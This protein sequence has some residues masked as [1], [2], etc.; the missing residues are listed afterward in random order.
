M[1]LITIDALQTLLGAHG[2]LGRGTIEAQYWA[3]DAPHVTI[4][5]TNVVFPV[6]IVVPIRSGQPTRPLDIPPTGGDSCVRWEIR[7]GIGR[8]LLLIRYTTIPATGPIEFGDLTDVDPNSYQRSDTALAAWEAVLAEAV[9]AAASAEY[10]ADRAG[11]SAVAAAG[12]ASA[13]AGSVSTASGAAGAAGASATAAAGSATAAGAAHTGAEAA[14]DT[15][16]TAR[17][18]AQTAATGAA[19]SASAA[20]GSAGAA[21]ASAT[22]AAGSA[23]AAGTARTGAE[24]ARDAAL[25][26]NWDG[27][28]LATGVDLD[29]I[30]TTGRYRFGSAVASSG[31]GFPITGAGGVLE[32]L[33]WGTGAS[34]VLQRITYISGAFAAGGTWTRRWNG[35]WGAWAWTPKLTVDSPADQPG[36]TLSVIEGASGVSRQLG[37]V[38]TVLG[39]VDLNLVT[40]VGSYTQSIAASATLARNYPIANSHGVLE[41]IATSGVILQRYTPLGSAILSGVVYQRRY[42]TGTSTWTAWA[43]LTSQRVDQAAGRAIYTYDDLNNRDQMVYGDTGWRDVSA[44]LANG[45]TGALYIRRVGVT[46]EVV[47]RGLD[48]ASATSSQLYTLPSG[49]MPPRDIPLFARPAA[50]SAPP[51][52]GSIGTAAIG[53]ATGIALNG[54]SFQAIYSTITSWPTTLPGTAVGTIPNL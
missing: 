41:V 24:A 10:D 17:T 3:G 28:D 11:S 27:T 7:S 33:R 14:R 53:V 47:G 52:Y 12:S 40:V 2:P 8:Q 36:A 34:N 23:T 32:V 37:V 15:A 45:W 19:G 54:N 4:E 26:A 31:T 50:S 20:S 43:A 44:N 6:P 49:F 35:S 38:G 1:T 42:F 39:T 48:S 46:I 16:V 21:G 30:T 51:A 13:A 22:A 5:G 9:G 29:T 25:A 18:D